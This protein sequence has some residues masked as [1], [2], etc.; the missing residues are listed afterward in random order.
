MVAQ[1]ELYPHE[2]R[3][4]LKYVPFLMATGI[5]LAVTNTKAVIEALVGKQTEFVRTPK[6]RLEVREE[7]W[8]GKK[9][10][11]RRAGWIPIIELC[12]AGYFLFTLIYSLTMENYLTTPFLLLFFM[13]YSYMGTMSLFQTPLRRLANALPALLRPRSVEP[14]T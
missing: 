13:G 3:H 11:R 14:A 5:G 4:R 7:G 9:Y 12:L 10:V 8:E 1:R 6:Y 2:W